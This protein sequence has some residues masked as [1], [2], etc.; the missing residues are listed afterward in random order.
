MDI[1]ANVKRSFVGASTGLT[2]WYKPMP[3]SLQNEISQSLVS[4]A[5]SDKVMMDA[6]R[7]SEDP[8]KA[9]NRKIGDVLVQQRTRNNVMTMR[10]CLIGITNGAEPATM[11]GVDLAEL[12]RV[13]ETL[14]GL[15]CSM[16]DADF[17]GQILDMAPEVG[18]D[19]WKLC[20]IIHDSKPTEQ[21]KK[22]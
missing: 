12:P 9:I 6:A 10:A 11:G 14:G 5:L 2:F 19:M 20:D 16:V 1:L 7:A 8:Q 15:P 22:S 17:L 4:E 3:Q 21:E 13:R 18:A